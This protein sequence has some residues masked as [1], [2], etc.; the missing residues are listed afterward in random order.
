M[1]FSDNLSYLA[2]AITSFLASTLLPI[3]S[4]ILVALYVNFKFN[5]ITV[6]IV[7]T[8]FNS[9]GSLTTYAIAYLGLNKILHRYYKNKLK[10]V[11]NFR[12]YIQKYGF[13]LAFFTFLPVIGDLFALTLGFYKYKL[14]KAILFI[15]LGKFTRYCFIIYVT[16]KLNGNT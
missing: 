7:A 11:Q 6:L 1:I 10:R 13:L 5:V 8:I 15:T 3:S 16:L 12:V 2:L 9:L 4:E 14:T